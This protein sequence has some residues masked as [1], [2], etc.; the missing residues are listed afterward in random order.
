[1]NSSAVQFAVESVFQNTCSADV[2]LERRLAFTLLHPT[3]TEE[4]ILA[5]CIL[6][7]TR[8]ISRGRLDLHEADNETLR[9]LFE[10]CA[11]VV[12]AGAGGGDG[13][14]PHCEMTEVVYARTKGVEDDLR[15]ARHNWLKGIEHFERIAAANRPTPKP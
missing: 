12:I 6:V 14:M 1:M 9:L 3:S 13:A 8:E 7:R 4:K 15:T 11:G 5:L 10:T 2:S